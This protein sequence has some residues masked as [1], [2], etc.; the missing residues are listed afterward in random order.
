MENWYPVDVYELALDALDG[1]Q[2]VPMTVV[3]FLSD[4]GY[5]L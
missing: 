2:E 1:D 3:E 5:K 4:Y